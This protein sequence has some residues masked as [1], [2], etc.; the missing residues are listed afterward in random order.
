M[1]YLNAVVLTHSRRS[2]FSLFLLDPR[3]CVKTQHDKILMFPMIEIFFLSVVGVGLIHHV[4]SSDREGRREG[5]RENKKRERVTIV[6]I[7]TEAGFKG[8]DT[9]SS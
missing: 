8:G 9:G 5:G 1:I 6:I 3:S 4:P 2:E 7:T